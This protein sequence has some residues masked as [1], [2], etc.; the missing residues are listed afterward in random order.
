VGWT[1]NYEM[2]FYAVFALALL[3]PRRLGLQLIF[4]CF[5]ALVALG[6]LCKP[7]APLLSLVTSWLL[8]DFLMGIAVAWWLRSRGKLSRRPICALISIGIACLAATIVWPP[9]E[10][11]PL[12][13]LLWGIPAALVVLGMSSVSIPEGRFGR[14]MSV[15]GDASYSIYLFQFFALPGWARVMRAAGAEVIPFDASVLILTALVTAS[16]YGCW[17]LLERPLGIVARSRSHQ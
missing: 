12:R 4:V 3:L 14:L 15:L 5:A 6:I 10:E 17:L 7:S 8:F 2:F 9:P 13:F 11:G 16:G 1:L